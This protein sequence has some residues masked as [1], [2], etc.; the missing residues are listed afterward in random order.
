MRHRSGLP[1]IAAA[2]GEIAA[3]IAG[4]AVQIVG[5]RFNDHRNAVHA[6]TFIADFRVIRPVAH[7]AFL[8]RPVDHV[9]R[10]RQGFR[11]LDGQP[12]TRVHVYVGHPQLGG[13]GDFLCQLREHLGSQLVLLAL[14]VLDVCPF[15]M[16]RHDPSP[17]PEILGA[18]LY[19]SRRVARNPA[20]YCTGGGETKL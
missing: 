6:V 15:R 13:N 14:A 10:H 2:F 18:L 19:T 17:F 12:Q 8:D 5:H 4:G 1:Q 16:A 3:H 9:L 11:G 20:P 7:L